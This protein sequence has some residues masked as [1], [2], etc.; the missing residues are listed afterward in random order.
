M[1]A[2]KRRAP[3]GEHADQPAVGDLALHEIFR[4]VGEAKPSQHS[5]HPQQAGVE[6]ELAVDAHLHDV[7][8]LLE[9]PGIDPAVGRQA[10]VD[11]TVLGEILRLFRLAARGEIG[12]RADYGHP[13]LRPD[14]HRDHHVP[15][16]LFAEAHAGVVALSDDV[17]EAIIDDE[18]DLDVGTA[19][20]E[21]CQRRPKDRLRRMLARG[22]AHRAGRRLTQ[23][24]ERRQFGVDLV[25]ARP[26][27]AEQPFAGLRRRDAAGGAGEKPQ[28]Q[29]LL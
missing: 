8:A 13:H 21:L 18:L 14:P 2:R 22:D 17:G 24:G 10:E 5:V 25:K 12:G 20:Q 11:A 7:A 26:D 3:V 9:L 4:D 27:R 28:A 29:P 6:H 15:G 16:D 19:R 23:C 1:I